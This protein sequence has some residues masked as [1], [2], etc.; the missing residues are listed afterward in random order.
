MLISLLL[1]AAPPPHLLADALRN[2]GP[3]HGARRLPLSSGVEAD[4]DVTHYTLAV[5]IDPDTEQVEG[6]ATIAATRLGDGPLILHASGPHILALT[7]DGQ[8]AAWSQSGDEV[9]ISDISGEAITAVVTWTAGGGRGLH[10]DEQVTWSFHEPEEARG[11]LVLRDVPEDKATL[12]WEVTVPAG[13][14][15]AANGALE[16]VSAAEPGW[17]TWTFTFDQPIPPYLMAVHVGDYAVLDMGEPDLPVTAWVYPGD[18][19]AA[20]ST[21]GNTLEMIHYLADLYAPY[22]WDRYGN[23]VTPIGGA[24]EHTT[25]TTFSD[26]LLL[27]D[28]W[29]EMVN[30]H[31]LGHHWWGD[32]VTLGSWADIWL[33]EGF[34]TYTEALWYEQYYGAEGLSEYAEYLATSYTQRQGGEGVFAVYDPENLWGGTVYKKGACVLH[35]L[36]GYLGDEAFF[37]ALGDYEERYRYGTAVTSD[38]IASVEESTGEDLGWFFDAWLFTAGE[39]TWTWGWQAEQGSGSWL[40]T[41]AIAQDRPEFTTRAPL[42]ITLADGSTVEETLW[43]ADEGAAMSLCLDTEPVAVELDPDSW[44]PIIPV[45]ETGIESGGGCSG[46]DTGGADP[47]V[48]PIGAAPAASGCAVAGAAPWVWLLAALGALRRRSQQV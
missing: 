29:G 41:I 11:W 46:A 4:W 45:Y 22:P 16:S 31:E 37:G 27:D 17:Q 25:V 48:T 35:M 13:L 2:R 8:P 36:R 24:M 1:A 18:E 43:V 23:A 38:F 20:W 3:I 40:L 12:R 33:N 47:Q 32:D 44:L 7:V 5:R 21:L 30:V 14:V 39:P 9:V 19:D 28:F 6:Q 34:A 10:F 15:V 42:R 26:A